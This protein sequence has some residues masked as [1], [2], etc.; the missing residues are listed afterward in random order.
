MVMSLDD[1][2]VMRRWMLRVKRIGVDTLIQIL[3]DDDWRERYDLPRRRV[4]EQSSSAR[5]VRESR[6]RR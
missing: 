2:I 5:R 1:R 3:L 6:W 4:S